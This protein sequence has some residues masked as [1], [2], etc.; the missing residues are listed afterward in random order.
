MPDAGVVMCHPGFVDDVLVG[1]DPLTVQR[2]QEF[3]FLRS[4]N[5]LPLLAASGVTLD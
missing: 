4:D 5:L 2:E 3:A 1:L